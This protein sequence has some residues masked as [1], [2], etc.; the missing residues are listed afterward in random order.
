MGRTCIGASDY[1]RTLYTFDDS[2]TP[3]PELKNFSIAH[4]RKYILPMLREAVN[5]NPELY[6]FSS[7]WS[8]PAWMKTGNS[9]LGGSMRKHYFA[10]YAQYFVKFIQ[11]YKAEGITIEA[12]TPQ[13]EV[14]TDQDGVMP[15][16]LW[17]QEYEMA[18]VAEFLGPA[19]RN[20]SIDT[21]I[22]LLDHNYSLWGRAVDELSDPGVFQFAE[23][24]A[25]HGYVGNPGAM[26]MVHDAFPTKSAYWTEG[27]PFLDSPDYALDWATWSSNFTGILK[28]WA[29]CVV[30][31]NLV[32][33]E[34]GRPNIGLFKCGGVVTLD[35]KT[36][37]ITHS[38]QYWALAHFSTVVRRGARVLATTGTA[39][40][41]DH[42]AF[43]NADG[44]YVL[45]LTNRGAERDINCGFQGKSLNLK[46]AQNSVVTLRWS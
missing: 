46:L 44:S 31:W 20:A 40:G 36:Q 15:A 16:A 27:G 38:G 19:F 43:A 10:P 30:A 13:N 42:I 9:L 29:R 8:P 35:S 22:W 39:P 45:V 24:V 26:S 7:P 17:A 3:D 41:I 14:D 4:D 18:F 23:G 1:S 12:V 37:K 25:W 5:V 21:K 6:L 11:A 28:N 2:P 32:L 34:N 33:D